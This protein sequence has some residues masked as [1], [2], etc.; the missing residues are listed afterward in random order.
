MMKRTSRRTCPEK[1]LLKAMIR[2][3]MSEK[4]YTQ[5]DM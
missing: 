2:V 1:G 4:R 5:D 3:M